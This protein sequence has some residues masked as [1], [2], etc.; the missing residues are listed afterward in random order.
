MRTVVAVAV[1][2]RVFISTSRASHLISRKTFANEPKILCCVL[3]LAICSP[4]LHWQA[5]LPPVSSRA[6]H[7]LPFAACA[8][9]NYLR[10]FDAP[11]SSSHRSTTETLLARR[12][13]VRFL[14]LWCCT[15]STS[16][17]SLSFAEISRSRLNSPFTFVSTRVLPLTCAIQLRQPLEFSNVVK[18]ATTKHIPSDA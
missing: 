3:C 17:P 10:G 7:L 6:A 15:T 5:K 12:P 14:L 2:A 9:S 16:S 11:H 4:A 13:V 8:K 18:L 1:G